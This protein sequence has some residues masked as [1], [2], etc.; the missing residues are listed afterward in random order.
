MSNMLKK[1]LDDTNV[2]NVT[3]TNVTDTN[4]TNVTD[5]NVTDTNVTD[6]NPA[7]TPTRTPYTLNR[8]PWVS[9]WGNMG[10]FA[11]HLIVSA[12]MSPPAVPAAGAAH[13]AQ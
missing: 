10:C 7:R 4:V 13:C 2:T 6:T 1:I 8:F 9:G 12:R 3:D 11:A 5:T